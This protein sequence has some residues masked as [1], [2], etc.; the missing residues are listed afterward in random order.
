MDQNTQPP[1]LN[2]NWTGKLQYEFG[3]TQQVEHGTLKQANDGALSGY[4]QFKDWQLP[5]QITGNQK[6]GKMNLKAKWTR[7]SCSGS[8]RLLNSLT[9]YT[10]TCQGHVGDIGIRNA[11]LILE[12]E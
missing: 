3:R 4:L 1:T 10:G 8:F 12:L 2:G 7:L 6:S 11:R 9:I 5:L